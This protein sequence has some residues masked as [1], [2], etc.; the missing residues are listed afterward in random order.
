MAQVANTFETYDAKGIR[1]ELSNT[2]HKTDPEE[3]PFMSLVGTSSIKTVH[4]EWQTDA[5]KSVDLTNN[6]PEGNEWTFD[7]VTATTR[8][9]NYAQISDVKFKISGTLDEIDKAG[10]ASEVAYQVVK[11]GIELKIDIE[12]ICLSNQASLAGSGDAATNRKTGGLPSWVGTN[13][14]T[15][16]TSGGYSATT[17]LTVA[18]I[19]GAQRAFTKTILDSVILAT[20]N[21]GGNVGRA[22]FMCSPYVKQVFSGFQ[23]GSDVALSRREFSPK[24]DNIIIQSAEGYRSDFGTVMVVPNR[25]MKR[26]GSAVARFAHLIDPEK[27]SIG[28]FRDI[29]V[30][31]PAKT[32]DA[33]NRV[34]LAE[35]AL[36]IKNEAHLGMAA[37]LYGLSAST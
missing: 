33:E 31:K 17:G 16:G 22:T 6:Q 8:V 32:G 26:A 30:E 12:A 11:K 10:R 13:D 20:Y 25:Q 4:P 1:E 2:I 24:G 9:G 29:R 19:T 18:A 36:I 21:S 5:L 37:D 14:D 7:P 3:T 35:Y 15:A 27:V 34:L 28:M 23:D